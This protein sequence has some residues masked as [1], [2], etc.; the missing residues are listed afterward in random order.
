MHL[1]VQH[2]R[3]WTSS[4]AICDDHRLLSTPWLQR[5]W[6]YGIFYWDQFAD[7]PCLRDVE[8]KVWVNPNQPEGL[9]WKS[10]DVKENKVSVMHYDRSMPS[11]GHLCASLVKKAMGDFTGPTLRIVGHSLGAQLAAHCSQIMHE[12]LQPSSPVAPSRVVLLDPVYTGAMQHFGR[13][14]RKAMGNAQRYFFHCLPI[15][16]TKKSFGREIAKNS[17]VEAIAKLWK[18][19]VPT[20]LYKGSLL[21]MTKLIGDPVRELETV[22]AYVVQDVDGG[23][24]HH[25]SL[26]CGHSSLVPLYMLRI[27]DP[28]PSVKDG[29]SIGNCT[30]PGPRCSDAQI[31]E[32]V[33]KN[34]ALIAKSGKR[35]VWHQENGI[36][37]IA[38]DDD[39]YR[40]QD[41]PVPTKTTLSNPLTNLWQASSA[42]VR[43]NAS[44]RSPLLLRK[45]GESSPK[46]QA[47]C[48]FIIGLVA[49]SLCLTGC[50]RILYKGVTSSS[51]F[52]EGIASTCL[53]QPRREESTEGEVWERLTAEDEIAGE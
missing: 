51:E 43:P 21:S 39:S 30:M 37:S 3:R 29:E 17:T 15:N 36:Y 52:N 12:Q 1:G 33:H 4:C 48:L 47:R 9:V 22:S 42:T 14:I 10:F 6:N 49:A 11:V 32:F 2:C 26:D 27:A 16:N 50:C 38:T 24:C 20:E 19:G 41:D 40:M 53:N 7:E 18:L 45:G 23:Y 28:Q 5:G 34:N 35:N 46:W 44:G 8:L 13:I 25:N 31:R